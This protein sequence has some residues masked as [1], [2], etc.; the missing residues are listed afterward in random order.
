MCAH[1]PARNNAIAA[2]LLRFFA[3]Q[4]TNR[5]RN[6]TSRVWFATISGRVCNSS[7]RCARQALFN[8][9]HCDVCAETISRL[10]SNAR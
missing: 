8:T 2:D 5:C 9:R 3:P 10:L 7:R 6:V 1:A 4:C